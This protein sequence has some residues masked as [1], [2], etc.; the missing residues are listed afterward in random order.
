MN[1]FIASDEIVFGTYLQIRITL[2]TN[3]F[4][5]GAECVFCWGRTL[6]VLETSMFCTGDEHFSA[7]DERIEN[8]YLSFSHTCTHIATSDF[9]TEFVWRWLLLSQVHVLTSEMGAITL[10]R[11]KRYLDAQWRLRLHWIGVQGQVELLLTH[12][13]THSVV[14]VW[15]G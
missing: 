3:M 9:Q 14:Q 4:I 15:P 1:V 13:C 8:A 11:S 6:L 2:Q 12:R 10:R 7:G 5:A